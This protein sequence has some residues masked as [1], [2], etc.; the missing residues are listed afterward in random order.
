MGNVTSL[1]E[2]INNFEGVTLPKLESQLRCQRKEIL[3]DYLF[4][5]AAGNNDYLLNY[6][7]LGQMTQSPQAFAAKL[8]S[9]YSGQLK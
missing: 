2:Q 1:N 3:S 7:L 8:I 6:F 5:I 9:S 4:L